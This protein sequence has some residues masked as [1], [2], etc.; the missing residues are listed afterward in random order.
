EVAAVVAGSAAADVVKVLRVSVD[1]LDAEI[2]LFFYHRHGEY[3]RFAAQI[4][5][6]HRV[7]GVR[8]GGLDRLVF[9]RVDARDV[10]QL[11]PGQ[12]VF[13]A[14]FVYE[15]RILDT[16]VIHHREAVD[17]GFPG[18]G[19]CFRGRDVRRASGYCERHRGREHDGE[20][21]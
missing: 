19:A 11:V 4:Q 6:D 17:V 3:H 14:L 20:Q 8:I 9:R 7:R 12:F 18:D 1:E 16:V 5:A 2:A 13:G 15:I 10:E 21:S